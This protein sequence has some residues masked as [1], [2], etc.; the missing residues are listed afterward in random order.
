MQRPFNPC[1]HVERTLNGDIDGSEHININMLCVWYDIA[2]IILSGAYDLY[3]SVCKKLFASAGETRRQQ[4]GHVAPTEESSLVW[5]NLIS[6][7]RHRLLGEVVRLSRS[8][9]LLTELDRKA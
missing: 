1:K 8:R 5:R 6:R 7:F 3:W 2:V 4:R 9:W